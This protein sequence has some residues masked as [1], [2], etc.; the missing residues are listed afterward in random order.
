M[1]TLT[2]KFAT[3]TNNSAIV[4]EAKNKKEAIAKLN[5]KGYKADKKN[6]YRYNQPRG[7]EHV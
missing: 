7:P 4:V 6:V 1:E 3:M 5:S 2:K